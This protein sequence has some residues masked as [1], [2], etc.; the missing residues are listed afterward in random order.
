MKLRG[1]NFTEFLDFQVHRSE[2]ARKGALEHEI[3][4]LW[5]NIPQ[6]EPCRQVF[7]AKLERLRIQ[8]I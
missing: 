4:E 6:Y 1:E 8:N 5:L 2:I 3:G 7:K